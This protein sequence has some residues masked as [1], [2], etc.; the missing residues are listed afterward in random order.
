MI[1]N[2]N[3]DDNTD[4]TTKLLRETLKSIF[5]LALFTA[6]SVGVLP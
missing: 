1:T 3:N 5:T 2:K 6:L 4:N